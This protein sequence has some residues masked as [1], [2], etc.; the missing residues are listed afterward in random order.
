MFHWQ[1]KIV[2][3]NDSSYQGS[4]LFLTINFPADYTFKSPK[5][6]FTRIYH[7][8]INSNESIS[9]DILR[10][11]WSPAVTILKVLLSTCS[12]VC[13]PNPDDP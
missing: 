12:L 9:L 8:N 10:S 5:V 13:D 6:A 4:V 11:Q 1:A 2:G 7:P 3:P